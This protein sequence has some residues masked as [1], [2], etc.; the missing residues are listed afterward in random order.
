M[1]FLLSL[2]F[3]VFIIAVVVLLF[4]LRFLRS[5]FGF[6]GRKNPFADGR[7]LSGEEKERNNPFNNTKKQ[8]KMIDKHEGEYVDYEEMK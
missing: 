4:A 1:G 7:N 8:K 5:I 6:G 3:F 2:I